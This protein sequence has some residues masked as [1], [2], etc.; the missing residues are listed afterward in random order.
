M[1]PVTGAGA[2]K[3]NTEI[4]LPPT[5]VMIPLG[6]CLAPYYTGSGKMPSFTSLWLSVS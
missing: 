6:Q 4:V 1:A 2:L 5:A 3:V